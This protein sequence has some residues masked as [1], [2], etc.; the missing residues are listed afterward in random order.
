MEENPNPQKDVSAQRSDCYELYDYVKLGCPRVVRMSFELPYLDWCRFENSEL[1]R[2]LTAYLEGSL[3]NST[4]IGGEKMANELESTWGEIQNKCLSRALDILNGECGS[5]ID[6]IDSVDQLV[7]IAVSIEKM[8]HDFDYQKY[9][10]E[11]V[12][13]GIGK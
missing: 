11:I 5:Y 9:M 1:F 6:E 3:K 10:D 2:N 13:R 8:K 12:S 4:G 7:G